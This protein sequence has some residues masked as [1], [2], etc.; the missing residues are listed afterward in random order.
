MKDNYKAFIAITIAFVCGSVITG[1][2]MIRTSRS[3]AV[4][5]PIPSH[6]TAPA[7]YFLDFDGKYKTIETMQEILNKLDYRDE[8]GNKLDADGDY[9]PHT[10]FALDAYVCD[11][12]GS[13]AYRVASI[14]EVD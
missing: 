6:Q 12:H 5:P 1:S 7:I 10:D 4:P 11:G 9:G 2:L 13:E 8:D 14:L 3:A